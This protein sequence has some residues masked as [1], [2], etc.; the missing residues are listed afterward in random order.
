MCSYKE[1]SHL[2]MKS[3]V[4]F[5]NK[6]KFLGIINRNN[7]AQFLELKCELMNTYGVT[8][9]EAINIINGYH[10]SDYVHKYEILNGNIMLQSDQNKKRENRELLLKIAELEDEL[11][12]I[13]M[14]NENI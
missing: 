10:I 12:K 6:A 3:A 2:T 9:I 7:S 4:Q 1:S 14:E 13:A 5:H 8:E 11:K